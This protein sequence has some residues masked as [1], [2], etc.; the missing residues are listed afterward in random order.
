MLLRTR[1]GFPKRLS[2][3]GGTFP[4]AN[5]NMLIKGSTYF[6]YRLS[7]C[8]SSYHNYLTILMIKSRLRFLSAVH[9]K[10]RSA[11]ER[12]PESAGCGAKDHLRSCRNRSRIT[13]RIMAIFHF[14]IRTIYETGTEGPRM[15]PDEELLLSCRNGI[16]VT[17]IVYWP[18]PVVKRAPPPLESRIAQ[19]TGSI[20]P[21]HP[22][23]IP[24]KLLNHNQH[25]HLLNYSARAK[26]D[27]W[28]T[29][30]PFSP[31]PPQVLILW[32]RGGL[33]RMN[34]SSCLV[35]PASGV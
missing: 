26:T 23:V 11:T 10:L 16:P 34:V 3:L 9:S 8:R 30:K 7:T 29:F 13:S 24:L 21:R 6:V 25:T 20:H 5:A 35:L 28:V 12:C 18:L 2:A 22:A 1:L 4:C 19:V 17:S 31:S 15:R 27:A 32:N 33:V 14:H